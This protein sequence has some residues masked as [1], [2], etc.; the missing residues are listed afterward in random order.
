[1]KQPF[2]LIFLGFLAA[3]GGEK[4]AP[5]G[6]PASPGPLP[7]QEMNTSMDPAPGP[8]P[9]VPEDSMPAPPAPVDRTPMP[10]PPKPG[11]CRNVGVPSNSSCLLFDLRPEPCPGCPSGWQRFRAEYHVKVDGVVHG[12]Q[13]GSF[14]V[15]G[16]RVDEF[17]SFMK[18]HSPASCGGMIVR[19]PCN[20]A[21]T[22][23]KLDIPWP[24]W[25]VRGR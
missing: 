9:G 15:H 20:P 11:A 14:Q 21:A 5:S 22:H 3:C 18:K 7:G 2:L 23:V 16:E 25:V 4:G 24:D 8:M 10:P 17:K 19:P 12:F 1:M 13:G 6:T